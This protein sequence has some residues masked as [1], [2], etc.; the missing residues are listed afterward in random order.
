MNKGQIE[1]MGLLIVVILIVMG[2]MFYVKFVVLAKKPVDQTS[3]QNI[4]ATNLI[5]AIMNIRVCDNTVT[6]KESFTLCGNNEPV[7]NEQNSCK[8]IQDQ[9]VPIIDS[10]LDFKYSFYVKKIDE[11]IIKIE[12]C[13]DEA[14]ASP[15]YTFSD[16]G[17]IYEAYFML[18]GKE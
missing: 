3:K 6:I 1:I 10:T 11:E 16:K 9:L 4:Q 5:N 7:C 17:T 14:T 8:Y 18:C 15:S 13:G 2:A 12:N